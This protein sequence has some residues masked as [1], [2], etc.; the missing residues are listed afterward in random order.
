MSARFEIV[1]TDAGW[2]ARYVA[3]N[4]ETVL[5]QEVVR[6]RAAAVNAVLS[7]ARF[8]HPD[9]VL[10]EARDGCVHIEYAVGYELSVRLVDVDER[11][12]A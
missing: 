4:N 7:T 2:H 5:V 9:A 8:F 12:E 6:R 11:V 10:I 3:G 1:H